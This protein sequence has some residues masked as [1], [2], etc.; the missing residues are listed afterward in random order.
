MCDLQPME[1]QQVVL[2]DTGML[3]DI[4]LGSAISLRVLASTSLPVGE[5]F[6]G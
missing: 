6:Q 3:S 5:G 4:Y 2:K 1:R